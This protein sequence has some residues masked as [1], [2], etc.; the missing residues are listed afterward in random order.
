MRRRASA[1]LTSRYKQASN[2]LGIETEP[3][4]SP[5]LAVR[6]RRAAP[7]SLNVA[8]KTWINQ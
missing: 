4:L 8:F 5:A 2:I 6:R 7:K 1:S 3:F